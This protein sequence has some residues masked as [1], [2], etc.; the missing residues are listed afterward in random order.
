MESRE[1]DA[2]LFN[3]DY[4]A[5]C[6]FAGLKPEPKPELTDKQKLDWLWAKYGISA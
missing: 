1:L 5:L 4:D 6:T 2:D 3:G